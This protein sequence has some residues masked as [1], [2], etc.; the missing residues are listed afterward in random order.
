MVD[1][2]QTYEEAVQRLEQ[3]AAEL[4]KGE[5][6]LAEQLAFYEEGM[7]LA[8]R[9]Q[10]ELEQVEERLRRLTEDGQEVSLDDR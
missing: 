1:K 2:Q 6:G 7:A 5:L 3:I 10:A 4:E 9:C 8:K